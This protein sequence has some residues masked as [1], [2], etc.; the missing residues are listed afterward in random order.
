MIAPSGFFLG[1]G[2]FLFGGARLARSRS[3]VFPIALIAGGVGLFALSV[4]VRQGQAQAASSEEVD[5]SVVLAA[6]QQADAAAAEGD[7]A[8]ANAALV[9]ALQGME[10]LGGRALSQAQRQLR[11]V[12]LR[13]YSQPDGF[14]L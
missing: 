10:G 11:T 13:R 5:L 2:D 6:L 12:L 14:C 7:C 9:Q 3:Q 1:W 4:W 8:A